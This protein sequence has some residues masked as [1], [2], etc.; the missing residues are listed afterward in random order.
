MQRLA[1]LGLGL[2]FFGAIMAVPGP[3]L[4]GWLLDIEAA[5]A[6]RFGVA[7]LGGFPLPLPGGLDDRREDQ[8]GVC[9]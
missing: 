4:A 6:L 3:V 9:K 7:G 5:G 2:A 1:T 8:H